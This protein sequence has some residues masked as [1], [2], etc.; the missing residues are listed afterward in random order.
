MA[1]VGKRAAPA[2]RLR[3]VHHTEYRQ[4]SD[5]ERDADNVGRQLDRHVVGAIEGIHQPCAAAVSPGCIGGVMQPRL[6]GDDAMAGE[7]GLNPAHNQALGG[8]VQVA[9]DV[10]GRV[11]HAHADV[12][13]RRS[14][15]QRAGGLGRVHG[16]PA[17]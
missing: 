4:G 17:G 5:A 9:D 3:I 15:H 14:A 16:D 8:Q 7:S 6:L 13:V 1:Q 12:L 10:S 11:L 2:G